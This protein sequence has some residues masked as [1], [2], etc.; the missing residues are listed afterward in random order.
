MSAITDFTHNGATFTARSHSN[1][2][3]P[4]SHHVVCLV[5]T[6]PDA[7]ASTFPLGEPVLVSRDEHVAAL[8]TSNN[9]T[10]FLR[11]SVE[12]IKR[13]A[14]ARVYVIRVAQGTDN[15]D[16]QANVIGGVDSSTGQRS[17]IAAITKLPE[18]PTL[19]AAPGFS[20]HPAIAQALALAAKDQLALVALNV[21]SGSVGTVTASADAL[22][23]DGSG[24]GGAVVVVGNVSVTSSQGELLL[25]GDVVALA[26][27]AG[28]E[29]WENI[30][31]RNVPI[32]SVEQSYEYSFIRA[33]TEGN[34]LNKHGV[35]Y[36]ATT[37]AGGYSIIGN[38]VVTGNTIS[39]AGLVREIHRQL[40]GP[41]E[42]A[43]GQRLSETYIE[44]QLTLINN[45]LDELKANDAIATGSHCYLDPNKNTA[46]A[47][48]A[49]R[50]YIVVEFD[51][52]PVNENPVIELFENNALALAD[53]T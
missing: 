10:G 9:N 6:A 8:D 41:L 44:Q 49:G 32:L 50:W 40:I 19:I 15:A 22:G 29:P 20:H 36:F 46:N 13:V 2:I 47:L 26:A 23:G 16:T 53:L 25:P 18:R 37:S 48:N 31:H 17:G 34:L 7:D 38:R 12:F 43:H 28:V 33:G 51:G 30:G 24:M 35:C 1:P 21:L 52:Y 45:W 5:S 39:D 14:D 3:G 42:K 27:L 11:Q 4:P